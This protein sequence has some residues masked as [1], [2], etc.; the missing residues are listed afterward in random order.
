MIVQLVI[1]IRIR[2][3]IALLDTN[4][5]WQKPLSQRNV[6][7]YTKNYAGLLLKHNRTFSNPIIVKSLEFPLNQTVP[8]TISKTF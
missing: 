2:R 4:S 7:K 5:T 1:K 8:E 6:S 3:F